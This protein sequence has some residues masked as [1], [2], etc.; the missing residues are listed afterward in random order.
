MGRGCFFITKWTFLNA[1]C[2][3]Y[4]SVFFIL[5]FI[6]WG[7]RICTLRTP[8]LRAWMGGLQY[9]LMSTYGGA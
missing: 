4:M 3:M 5:H 6:I 2:I 7:V 1:G 9:R 8:C